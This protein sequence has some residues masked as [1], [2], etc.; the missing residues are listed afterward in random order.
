MLDRWN[1]IVDN[2]HVFGKTVEHLIRHHTNVWTSVNA[3][4]MAVREGS[5][6]L[7][8]LQ[9]AVGVLRHDGVVSPVGDDETSLWAGASDV[10]IDKSQAKNQLIPR[11]SNADV[12]VSLFGSSDVAPI[13]INKRGRT[14]GTKNKGARRK[15][16]CP[17]KGCSRWFD[18]Q[19][20]QRRHLCKDK[21]FH[22]GY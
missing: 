22:Y 19:G 8:R 13:R 4:V 20:G 2:E 3:K 15:P 1:E 10:S 12:L 5:R 7:K 16:D 14:P 21:D 9:R 11:Q 18:C 6:G 17:N